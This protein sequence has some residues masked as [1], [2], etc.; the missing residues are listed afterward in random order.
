[1]GKKA[2]IAVIGLK[3]LPAFG[4]AATV[5]ENIINHLKDQYDFAVYSIASH[6][7]KKSRMNGFRQI[8]FSSL[9]FKKLNTLY[10]Y[11]ISAL[12]AILLEKYDLIHLHHKDAAF[13]ICILTLRYKVVLTTHGGFV[14]MPKWKKFSWFFR[15][16]EKYFVRLSKTITCV[17]KNEQRLYHQIHNIRTEHI[18]NGIDIYLSEK[19]SRD[20]Q[21]N[22][23][24]FF[25]AGRIIRTKGCEIML[26]ALNLLNY[27][28]KILIAG[29]LDQTLDYK[30]EVLKLSKKLDVEFLGLIKD[31]NTLFD[32]IGNAKLFI[33]PS[34]LE[35]MSMMLLE[36]SAVKVPIIAS[37]IIQ[38]KDVFDES[39]VL[40]FQTDNPDDLAEKISWAEKNYDQMMNKA[41]NA[42]A[43]VLFKHNWNV[44]ASQY[45]FFYEKNLLRNHVN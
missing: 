11:I 30:Q 22:E 34:S 19:K 18:P 31:K 45:A 26:Q 4:G 35:A 14:S 42:L 15:L 33:F 9:P 41:E 12:H 1:M 27:K 13:I 17:S 20:Q 6:A 25:G 16:Q 8:V 21:N 29:D 2:K 44:I 43:K 28:G 36:A 38:N 39:E 23:Y 7:E 10:Y 37:D 24:L 32:L 40:F 5:G 3:G